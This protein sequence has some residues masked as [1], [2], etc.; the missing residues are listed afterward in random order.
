[1]NKLTPTA[2][3][4]ATA[5][6]MTSA[7]AI[8]PL[9]GAAPGSASSAMPMSGQ[10]RACDFSKLPWVDAV[11]DARP[12]AHVR[13]DGSGMLVATVDIATALPNTRYD[14]RVIQTPRPSAYC[15]AGAPGVVT[16]TLQT[17]AIGGGTTTFGGPVADSATGAWVILERPSPYAQAPAEFYT[18]EFLASV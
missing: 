7:V 1:M 11:G 14:V 4:V 8:A 17:D 12:V 3:V 13:T 15:G 6:L 9:A 2:C 16:G 10:W 18:T 5:A